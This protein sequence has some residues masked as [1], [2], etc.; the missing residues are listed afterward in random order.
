LTDVPIKG[1]FHL[2]LTFVTE[3]PPP[4]Q[5]AFEEYLMAAEA[6]IEYIS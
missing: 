4:P 3:K 5:V 6:S 1:I 2:K